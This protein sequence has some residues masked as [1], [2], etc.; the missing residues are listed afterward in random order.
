MENKYEN[1]KEISIVT[2][3]LKETHY[4]EKESY[5]DL[6]RLSRHHISYERCNSKTKEVLCSWSYKTSSKDMERK[7]RRIYYGVKDYKP[8]ENVF[9][10]EKGCLNIRLTYIDNTYVNYPYE[11]SLAE[12]GM[13]EVCLDILDIIPKDEEYS[14]LLNPFK[15]R[16]LTTKIVFDLN[17]EDI[18]LIKE[19]D[20]DA[21]M[22][23]C[24]LIVITK[25]YYCYESPKHQY[26]EVFFDDII[27]ITNREE[28]NAYSDRISDVKIEGINKQFIY[29]YLGINK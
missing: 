23:T 2:K 4:N 7:L 25:D 24:P 5:E 14:E 17:R 19:S 22:P 27:N 18:V 21:P 26:P 28:V 15:Y 10:K 13:S 29:L 12:N 20:Y 8:I 16:K 11:G 6:L 9:D 1:I 3:Y